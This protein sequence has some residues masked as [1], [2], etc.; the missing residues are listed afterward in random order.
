MRQQ[1]SPATQ[2]EEPTAPLTW[3]K[4]FPTDFRIFGL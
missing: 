2:I 1:H 4:P 3:L